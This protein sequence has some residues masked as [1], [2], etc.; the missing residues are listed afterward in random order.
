MKLVIMRHGQAEALSEPDEARALT[1]FGKQQVSEA[2][3]WLKEQL[4]E[5][6]LIDL[7]LVSPY[8]RAQE[9]YQELSLVVNVTEKA[10]SSDITPDGN[11]KLFHDYLDALVSQS[12][13]LNTV[14]V[15]SHMPFVC[16]FLEEINRNKKSILFDTSS[17]VI[18]DYDVSD[19]QGEFTKTFHP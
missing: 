13:S 3:K 9:T 8:L 12:Q 2:S 17:I 1:V 4:G 6:G 15:V 7:A 18:I 14:L 19:G 5:D 11:S 16:Y 10:N